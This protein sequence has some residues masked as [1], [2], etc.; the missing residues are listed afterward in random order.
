VSL[1]TQAPGDAVAAV[2]ARLS[3]A[4]LDVSVNSGAGTIR[5]ATNV[6]ALV[7]CG[8]FTQRIDGRVAEFPGSAPSAVIFA[9]DQPGDILVREAR[10]RST[11]TISIAGGDTTTATISESHAVTLSQ[12]SPASGRTLWRESLE[13]TGTASASFADGTRCRSSGALRGIVS[14]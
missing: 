8:T 10:V 14:G 6:D 11:A 2:A 1:G 4:G 9:F 13:F 7:D 5:V 3:F 12:T